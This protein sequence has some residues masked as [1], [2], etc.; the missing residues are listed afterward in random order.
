[1]LA[2]FYPRMAIGYLVKTGYQINWTYEFNTEQRKTKISKICIRVTAAIFHMGKKHPL[3]KTNGGQI[4]KESRK[5][6]L[7]INLKPTDMP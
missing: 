3:K 6:M 2:T 4:P 1:M 5:S 7:W